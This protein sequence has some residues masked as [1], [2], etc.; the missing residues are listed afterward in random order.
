MKTSQNTQDVIDKGC[1]YGKRYEYEHGQQG[2]EINNRYTNMDYTEEESEFL[3]L[4][5]KYKSVYGIKFPT[6]ITI[7]RIAKWFLKEKQNG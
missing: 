5:D 2:K 1:L 4:V 3:A 7:F 6:Y